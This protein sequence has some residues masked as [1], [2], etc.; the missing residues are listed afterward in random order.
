M[1]REAL[2]FETVVGW[3]SLQNCP[4]P[5][6][7]LNPSCNVLFLGPTRVH[8]PNWLSCSSVVFAG[9]VVITNKETVL[10]DVAAACM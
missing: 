1:K 9:V 7:Y 2:S 10:L 3:T 5:L 6:G 8:T 4:F